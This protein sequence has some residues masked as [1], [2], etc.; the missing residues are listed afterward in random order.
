METTLTYRFKR[1]PENHLD[2]LVNIIKSEKYFEYEGFA[3]SITK[4]AS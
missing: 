3:T 4:K 2:W 1:Q